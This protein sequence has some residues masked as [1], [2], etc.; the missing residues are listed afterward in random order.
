MSRAASIAL[1]CCAAV[2]AAADC[3]FD[4]SGEITNPFAPGSAT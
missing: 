2:P 4:A 1:A 3:V